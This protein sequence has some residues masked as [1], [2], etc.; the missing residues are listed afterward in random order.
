MS[1]AV[2]I[3]K[4]PRLHNGR[5]IKVGQIVKLPNPLALALKA[6]GYAVEPQESKGREFAEHRA[7][8][9]AE[10]REARAASKKAEAK[11]KADK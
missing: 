10:A 11:K 4:Q 9:R 7:L 8:A 6:K 1:I 3:R 2:E 5:L